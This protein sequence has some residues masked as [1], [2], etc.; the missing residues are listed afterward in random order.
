[1]LLELIVSGIV[2]L[3]LSRSARGRRPEILRTPSRRALV[4][5]MSWG[6]A[7][8]LIVTNPP[9]RLCFVRRFLL[10]G[11]PLILSGRH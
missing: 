3:R 2:L 4:R 10:L 1:M 11:S 8:F 9:L 6:F 5:S 7:A